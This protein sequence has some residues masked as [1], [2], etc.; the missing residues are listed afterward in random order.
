MSSSSSSSIIEYSH[1]HGDAHAGEHA[2]RRS[3]H[4]LQPLRNERLRA[5]EVRLEVNELLLVAVV[6]ALEA[7]EK[8]P[9]GTGVVVAVSVKGGVTRVR[10]DHHAY[11][12]AHKLK[13]VTQPRDSGSTTVF[14]KDE[15]LV[16]RRLQRL[17]MLLPM[18]LT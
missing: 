1:S 11:G 2:V 13:Q 8:R 16:P 9:C 15:L 18:P 3:G 17:L 14:N 6:V 5:V 7:A 10:S 12:G 4:Y